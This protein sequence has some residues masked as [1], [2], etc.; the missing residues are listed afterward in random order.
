MDTKL[1][2]LLSVLCVNTLHSQVRDSLST[3]NIVEIQ[4]FEPHRRLL[5]SYRWKRV[6]PNRFECSF[7]RL[8]VEL[9]NFNYYLIE[10]DGDKRVLF[11]DKDYGII[12]QKIINL[13]LRS[14]PSFSECSSPGTL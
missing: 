6:S 3:Q 5:D 9:K 13:T 4:E 7:L 12:S 10:M 11:V 2:L 1:L 14:A 8:A